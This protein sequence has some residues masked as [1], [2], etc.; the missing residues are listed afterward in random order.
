M[1]QEDIS[2]TDS[3]CGDPHGE[4]ATTIEEALAAICAV[5]EPVNGSESVAVR[6]ALGR[7]L[8]QEV[9]SRIDV[10]AHTN[11]A[12]DGY[13]MRAADLPAS[14]DASLRVLGT[15]WAGRPFAD[16]VGAGTCVRIMTGAPV[17]DGADTVVM[18]EQVRTE[19][20]RIVVGAGHRP[21]QNVRQ[22][23]EDI[24]AGA[25]ALN[26]GILLRPPHLGMIASLGV[27][28][29][30][31]RRRP[32]VA[33]FSTG[34][35]LQSVGTPLEEGQ[36]YDSNRYTIFGMLERLGVDMVD[37]GVVPDSRERTE[38]AFRAAA[39]M[40]DAIV[41]SGGVSVGE[42][43]Y[44]TETLEKIGDVGFW[45]VAIKPGRPIAFGHVGNALFFGLPGNP[46]SAMVTFYQ[47]VRPALVR[48]AGIEEPEPD[49]LVR[50]TC[51]STL[52]KKP[53]RKEFQR[54]KLSRDADGRYIVES[55]GFQGAGVLRSMA[56]ANCFIV[57]PLD[58]GT[59]EPGDEVDVQPF[60]AL[61]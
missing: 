17:P 31:V 26:P 1:G 50:A 53:G 33:F 29:V 37:M 56:E 8:D 21:G 13:A 22:A 6:S 51:R 43:D 2:T 47:V 5:I 60:S 30:R 38:E 36:I 10:P 57:L 34:D 4:P 39:A 25:V 9:R 23:G 7:I 24:R 19:G 20:E 28:E 16:S 54:G 27:A 11:S 59:V 14:G 55:T 15:A 35:E 32:R 48:L 3:C 41:T 12:M 45:K 40:A 61:C 52:R 18:Q 58:G 42:A 49:L 44:V 46:V